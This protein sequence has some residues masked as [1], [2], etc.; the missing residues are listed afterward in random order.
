MLEYFAIFCFFGSF[1]G[2][3]FLV[4]QKIPLLIN[5][6]E[7]KVKEKG[8]FQKLKDKIFSLYPF[9]NFSFTIFLQKILMRMRIFSMK[10]DYKLFNLIKK[11]KSKNEENK[12]GKKDDYW[13]RLKKEIKK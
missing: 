1:L 6:P 13:E 5:F 8:F 12:E 9:K 4:Y 2:M 10:V 7:E 11:L 3:S